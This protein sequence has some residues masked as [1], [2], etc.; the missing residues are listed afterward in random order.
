TLPAIQA[1]RPSPAGTAT[2]SAP[3]PTLSG[4]A[5]SG[6][7][8]AESA[9]QRGRVLVVDDEELVLDLISDTCCDSG[10]LVHTA[11]SLRVA[12]TIAA[13]EPPDYLIVDAHIDDGD[14][15][16]F[17]QE[18][19]DQRPGL[20]QRILLITGDP[21]ANRAQA[22]RRQHDCPVLPKPFRIA[23]LAAAVDAWQ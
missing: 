15:G 6:A 8:A 21:D 5:A 1:M 22:I 4:S 3:T 9:R 10:F 11:A 16:A 20:A 19:V 7:E 13:T 17:V 23:D 12:R 2:P 18:L 14:V